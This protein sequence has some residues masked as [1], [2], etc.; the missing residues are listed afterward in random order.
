VRLNREWGADFDLNRFKHE[1]RWNES[2]RRMEAYLVATERTEVNV[3]ALELRLTLEK[4]ES[5]WTE[6]SHRFNAKEL[7]A[8]A[9][10][11][12]FEVQAQ[13][14]DAEWPFAQTLMVVPEGR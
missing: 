3:R 4:G 1:A 14:V 13:W 10:E 9:R 12:G 7:D 6:S 8:W 11:A 2:E 5:L